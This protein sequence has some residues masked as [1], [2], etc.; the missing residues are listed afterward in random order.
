MALNRLM[1]PRNPYKNSKPNFKALAEKYN[2]MQKYSGTAGKVYL[3]FKNPECLRALTWTLL[4]E[5]FNLDILM[6]SDRLIPTV[7]L[8]LNYILWLEDLLV[9]LPKKS[10]SGIDIGNVAFLYGIV[11]I[12]YLS[13]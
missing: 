4:K 5:D 8:R 11:I 7:P 13:A 9:S 3:D 1:H 6:P 10:I 12:L 2:I